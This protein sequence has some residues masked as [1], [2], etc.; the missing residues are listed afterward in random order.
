MGSDRLIYKFLKG[1]V[2][3]YLEKL[4]APYQLDRPPFS[5]T[6]GLPLVPRIFKG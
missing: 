5:Q 3:F 6:A 1:T 4:I 2:A